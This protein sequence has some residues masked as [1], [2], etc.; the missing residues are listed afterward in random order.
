MNTFA[1]PERREGGA[2]CDALCGGSYTNESSH[3]A[4]LPSSCAWV[5]VASAAAAATR[6]Y[7]WDS[8]SSSDE[9]TLLRAGR[10]SKGGISGAC[11][12][13]GQWSAASKSSERGVIDLAP[14]VAEFSDSDLLGEIA[15][16]LEER[17]SRT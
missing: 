15:R 6:R 12:V 4:V 3:R 5:A 9:E 10:A 17:T 8:D 14:R 11:A 7:Y 1:T 2:K 13:L 16:R